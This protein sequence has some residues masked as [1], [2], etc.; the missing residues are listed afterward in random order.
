[1]HAF[2][3]AYGNICKMPTSPTTLR[4]GYV[5]NWKIIRMQAKYSGSLQTSEHSHNLVLGRQNVT[6]RIMKMCPAWRL[7][8]ESKWKKNQVFICQ[9]SGINNWEEKDAINKFFTHIAFAT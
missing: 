6:E 8:E 1:M 4:K 2:R 9:M 5:T 3:R 7:K